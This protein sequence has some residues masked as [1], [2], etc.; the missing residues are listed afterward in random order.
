LR[1]IGA[2]LDV[3]QAGPYER[4]LEATRATL[5]ADAYEREWELGRAMSMEAA[6]EYALKRDPR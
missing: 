5:G 6:I 2:T 4:T 3:E 1:V